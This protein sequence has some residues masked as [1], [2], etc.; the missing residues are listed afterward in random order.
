LRQVHERAL[1]EAVA[2]G[3]RSVAFPAI[4]TGA[5]RFP[6]AEAAPIAL[7]SAREHLQRPQSVDLVRFVLFKPAHLEVFR[8]ALQALAGR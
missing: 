6:P 5:Y 2:R 7:A 3:C 4:S 1:E 8:A